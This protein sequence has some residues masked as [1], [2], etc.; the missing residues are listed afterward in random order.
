[1]TTRVTRLR[2]AD[3]N[4]PKTVSF[5]AVDDRKRDECRALEV[6]TLAVPAVSARSARGE[7]SAPRLRFR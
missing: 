4:L 2:P 6:P 7:P 5:T 3:W 1:M